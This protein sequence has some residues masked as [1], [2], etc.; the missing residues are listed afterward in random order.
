MSQHKTKLLKFIYCEKVTKFEEIFGRGKKS[1]AAMRSAASNKRNYS[2][3]LLD[4][5]LDKRLMGQLINSDIDVA[6]GHNNFL[7]KAYGDGT[8]TD[9]EHQE[10]KEGYGQNSNYTKE[11][12]QLLKTNFDDETNWNYL[13]M[14]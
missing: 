5:N 9:F 7:H 4:Q 1:F 8:M 12:E 3:G 2:K 14:N 6:R 13:F 11:K 10:R